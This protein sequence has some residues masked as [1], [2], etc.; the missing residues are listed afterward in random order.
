MRFLTGLALVTA[1]LL[2]AGCGSAPG[3]GDTPEPAATAAVVAPLPTR[4][5]LPAA[6]GLPAATPLPTVAALPPTA[7]MPAATKLPAATPLPPATPLPTIAPLPPAT[8][9][10]APTPLPTAVP[11]PPVTVALPAA[12]PTPL[13]PPSPAAPPT[14]TPDLALPL[15]TIGAFTW[16]VE[17]A[18][19]GEEQAQG[20]SG[21]AELAAGSGMLFVWNQESRRAFWMPDMNFP[22]DLVW[23]NG[24]C[25][26]VQ[27]T[28]A[29]PPQ[30]PGQ[31]RADLP[32]YTVDG[33]QYV[34]EINAGEAARRGIN[35]GDRAKFQGRLVG[36]YGC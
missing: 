18:L 9:L 3:L 22:L 28:A 14:A 25:A 17:L 27:I 12:T 5:A 34:L 31:S 30:A 21:R 26:V 33:V 4:S 23:L 19:T 11:L 7:P 6:T 29:A 36:E 20:L 8:A 32:R 13:P 24:E 16:P 35:V 15:V 2:L 1:A 10:P